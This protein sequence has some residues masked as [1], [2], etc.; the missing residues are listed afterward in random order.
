MN[1]LINLTLA[2]ENNQN[3]LGGG[4]NTLSLTRATWSIDSPLIFI[5]E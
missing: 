1:R 3:T 5:G 4:I 2:T